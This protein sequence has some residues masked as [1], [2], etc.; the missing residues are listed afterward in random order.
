[1][2]T[3][4]SSPE[5]SGTHAVLDATAQI[6]VYA[7]RMAKNE[8]AREL[9]AQYMHTWKMLNQ[10]VGQI[11]DAEWD[12]AA[13]D[14]LQPARLA[15]HIMLSAEFYT[16]QMSPMRERFPRQWDEFHSEHIPDR[17]SFRAYAQRVQKGAGGWL[18]SESLDTL[19]ERFPWAGTTRRS[20]AVFLLRHSLYHM[21]EMNAMLFR[22][23]NGVTADP[24]MG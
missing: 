3:H 5:Y 2:Q 23:S 7:R 18:L 1:M 22:S 13:P 16:D 19:E 6:S 15:L 24:W 8:V 12:A 4:S 14:Y 20:V 21:G 11:S 17:V 10:L 9:L